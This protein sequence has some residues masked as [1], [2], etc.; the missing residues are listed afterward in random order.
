MDVFEHIRKEHQEIRDMLRELAGG[1]DKQLAKK[2]KLSITAHL[3]AEEGSIYASLEARE[4]E[5]A[6][7]A[8][9]G[10]KEIRSLAGALMRIEAEDFPARLSK[11]AESLH[12]HFEAEEAV[13]NKA[14]EL[15]D[16]EKVDV[17]SY[18]FAEIGRRMKESVL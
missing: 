7:K 13:L 16:Q 4:R 6:E 8:R 3:N 9:A 11:L 10:H 15:F 18:Q 5:M 14:R 12:A 2:L 17:L 1:R